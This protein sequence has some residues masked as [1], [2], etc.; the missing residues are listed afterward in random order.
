MVRQRAQ[1]GVAQRLRDRFSVLAREAVDNAGQPGE[2]GAYTRDDVV[3]QVLGGL[4]LGDDVIGKVASIDAALEDGAAS[5][6]Q[7]RLHVVADAV[8]G[9]G[10]E[11]HDGHCGEEALEDAELE[12]VRPEVMAPLAAAVGFV[13]DKGRDPPLGVRTL[14]AR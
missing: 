2:G 7:H 14:E 8:C 6:S 5:D 12:V 3:E 11:G 13:D 9:R 4:G 1:P 10:C